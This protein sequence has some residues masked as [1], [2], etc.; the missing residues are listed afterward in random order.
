MHFLVRVSELDV[1]GFTTK[2]IIVRGQKQRGKR[3]RK[4]RKV[5]SGQSHDSETEDV[6]IPGGAIEAESAALEL[7]RSSLNPPRIIVSDPSTRSSTMKPD[8]STSFAP[9]EVSKE[10]DNKVVAGVVSQK[11]DTIVASNSTSAA[12]QPSKV[13]TSTPGH[14]NKNELQDQNQKI[15]IHADKAETTPSKNASSTAD[16]AVSTKRKLENPKEAGEASRARS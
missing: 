11:P 1:Q 9:S 13:D 15:F 7:S 8:T 5:Q 4:S 10:K 14:G 6:L 3:V 16:P 12:A 2:K